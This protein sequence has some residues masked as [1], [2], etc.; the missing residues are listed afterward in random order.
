MFK[1]GSVNLAVVLDSGMVW[2]AEGLQ[3]LPYYTYCDCLQL[4]MVTVHVDIILTAAKH[5]LH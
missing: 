3:G 1:P 5:I 2:Q 4:D